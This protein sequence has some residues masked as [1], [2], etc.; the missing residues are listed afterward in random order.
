MKYLLTLILAAGACL[1]LHAQDTLYINADNKPIPKKKNAHHFK[2]TTITDTGYVVTLLDKNEVIYNTITYKD[3]QQKTK[4]GYSAS[5]EGKI[6]LSEGRYLDG[7]YEGLWKYYHSNGRLA[8]AVN[9][10]KGKRISEEYFNPDG[11]PEPDLKKTERLPSFPG[12]MSALGAYMGRVLKYP[13]AAREKRITGVVKVGFTV[14]TTGELLNV[15]AVSSPHDELSDEALRV[16]RMMPRWIP[17]IQFNRPVKV[18]YVMPV[19]FQVN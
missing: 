7:E 11:S 16:V 5:Y 14:S 17:G 8:G 12:G 13:P 2:V 18:A 4:H 10:A 19:H 3:A 1:S 6:L 15:K 9:Y